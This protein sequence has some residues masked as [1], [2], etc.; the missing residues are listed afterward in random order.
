M[1]PTTP[2]S[3]AGLRARLLADRKREGERAAVPR[4]ALHPD[5]AAVRLYDPPAN[6]EPETRAGKA[7]RVAR[8]DTEELLEHL[9]LLVRGNPHAQVHHAY[10]YAAIL[11]VRAQTE[12]HP[13]RGVARGIRE[14]VVYYLRDAPLVGE[15]GRDVLRHVHLQHTGGLPDPQPLGAGGQQPRKLHRV[16][17]H[18]Q[19]ARFDARHV[20]EV[21]HQLGQAVGLLVDD[22]QELLPRVRVEPR[23]PREKGARVA[24]DQPQRRAQLVA[25]HRHEVRLEPV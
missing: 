2:G 9:L 5:A 16:T 12:G 7:A 1:R 25:H 3:S 24:L 20:Q 13:G 10:L 18:A 23:V 11:H 22:L 8:I 17:I 19:R 4:L 15:H 21:G 6:R 14:Q